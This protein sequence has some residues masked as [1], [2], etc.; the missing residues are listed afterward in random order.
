MA[1]LRIRSDEIDV[2]TSMP[3]LLTFTD[4][5]ERQQM[6]LRAIHGRLASGIAREYDCEQLL[7]TMLVETESQTLT[8]EVPRGDIATYFE[9][10]NDL[11]EPFPRGSQPWGAYD[12]QLFDHWGEIAHRWAR[13]VPSI[14]P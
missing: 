13:Q 8:V 5:T 12:N 11:D 10:A 2:V 14:D 1:E 3:N 6:E 4:A 9:L 7:E